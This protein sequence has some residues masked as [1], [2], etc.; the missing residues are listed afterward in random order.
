MAHPC[1]SL[2]LYRHQTRTQVQITHVLDFTNLGSISKIWW[3]VIL[4]Q[5]KVQV[6][7][8]MILTWKMLLVVLSDFCIKKDNCLRC[9]FPSKQNKLIIFLFDKQNDQTLKNIFQSLPFQ[10]KWGCQCDDFVETCLFF[11]NFVQI[12]L[13]FMWNIQSCLS[14]F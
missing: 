2:A 7:W 12:T 3:F 5:P 10:S 11:S 9:L 6:T 4:C 8:I 14:K 13:A 1:A